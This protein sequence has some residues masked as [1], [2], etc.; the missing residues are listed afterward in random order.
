M[1]QPHARN[2]NQGI[3]PHE[4]QSIAMF[5]CSRGSLILLVDG[6]PGRDSVVMADIQVILLF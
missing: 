6:P 2:Q 1:G 5:E 4:R 3:L